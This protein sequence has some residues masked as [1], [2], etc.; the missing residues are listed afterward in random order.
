VSEGVLS[1][2]RSDLQPSTLSEELERLSDLLD[3]ISSRE[4]DERSQAGDDART[5]SL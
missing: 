1:R 5:Q 4:K 2:C 3:E